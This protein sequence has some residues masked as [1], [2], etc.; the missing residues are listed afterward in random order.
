MALVIPLVAGSLLALGRGA[1]AVPAGSDE[2]YRRALSRTLQRAETEYLATLDLWVDHSRWDDP[3]LATSDHFEVRTIESYALAAEIAKSLEYLRGEWVKLLGTGNATAKKQAVWIFPN[4]AAYNQFGEGM[5]DQDAAQHS[6]AYA[7]FYAGENAEQPVVTYFTPNRTQLGMWITHG[8]VHQYLQQSFAARPPTWIS[9]GL[10]S[11]FALYWDW[12]WGAQELKRLA[13]GPRFVR[14][15]RLAQDPLQA[16]T[17]TADE[18]FIEL[19]MLFHYLLNFCPATK[20]G[21]EGQPDAGPF[22]EFLR[23][24][25]RGEDVSRTH[26]AQMFDEAA[27][28]LESDLKEFDFAAHGAQ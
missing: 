24:A 23:A 11:Y 15:E 7:S 8:A 13:A 12:S 25:V 21:A 27:D 5:S 28:L 22:R 10:A 20:N 14:I 2:L 19:G 4:M 9:E 17:G 1:P 3:W 6:S 16:Y 18:R 26:F